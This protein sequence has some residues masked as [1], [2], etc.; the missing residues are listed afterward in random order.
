MNVYGFLNAGTCDQSA[1]MTVICKVSS[2]EVPIPS[3]EVA[4]IKF[5]PVIGQ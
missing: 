5:S 4:A 3:P 2:G 1:M